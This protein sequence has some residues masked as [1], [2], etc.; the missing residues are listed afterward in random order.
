ML[1]NFS[2]IAI[3]TALFLV[4]FID[5]LDFMIVMPL[6]PDFAHEL[7][8]DL[9]N[10]GW[11]ASSYTIAAAIVGIASS[12]FV[13]NF[14]RKQV[15]IITLLGLMI[16]NLISANASDIYTMIFSRF[17]AGAFGGPATSI[18]YAIV[19][20]LFSEQRR[21]SIM[22]KIMS[23]F[24]L[25]A[26]LG[27]PIGLEISTRFSW[28]AS[29]YMVSILCVLTIILTI[30]FLPKITEHLEH[31]KENKVTYKSLIGKKSYIIT[32][33]ATFFGST[34]AFMIIPYISPFVQNNLNFP[35][36]N[37]GHIY[38][39]GGLLSFFAMNIVGKFVD[40]T[41][42]SLA[43][44]L[45][46]FFIGFTLLLGFVFKLTIIPM[47]ILFAPFMVGM[48]IRNVSNYTLYSKVPSLNDRAGF[49]S[50]I[51]CVQHIA[52]SFG[53]I[54]TSMI[55][56]TDA[57]GHLENNEWVA[58]VALILFLSVPILLK[59]VEKRIYKS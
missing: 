43:T 2:E 8:I 13:D 19:S 22:G 15:L 33:I 52:S 24:S 28:H 47:I 9:S 32:F 49:M 54:L 36:E 56:T 34:A 29:F 39:V 41:S 30:V 31:V 4:Q 57:R 40:K 53:A 46:N 6:G 58:L 27:V 25:A 23:G 45:A 44:S 1:R 16:A 17:F 26:I 55:L 3:I 51:S 50:V 11:L 18:C 5:V 14:D 37:V 7:D 35:R 59:D 12:K 42:S 48:A 10:L 21:G 20:D 38:F